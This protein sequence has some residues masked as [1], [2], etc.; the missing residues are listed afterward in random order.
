M[1]TFFFTSRCAAL[2]LFK[3]L[4]WGAS[5]PFDFYLGTWTRSQTLA[6]LKPHA[7]CHILGPFTSQ[8]LGITWGGLWLAASAPWFPLIGHFRVHLGGSGGGHDG[9]WSY[10]GLRLRFRAI[11]QKWWRKKTM[12]T[13]LISN[14]EEQVR[15]TELM[16]HFSYIYNL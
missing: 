11:E 14:M 3:W 13:C 7:P 16:L 15:I 4:H 6:I 12:H 2:R 9:R 5:L 10:H 1:C 8:G